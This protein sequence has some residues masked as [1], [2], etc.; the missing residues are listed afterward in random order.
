[1]QGGLAGWDGSARLGCSEFQNDSTI[2]QIV[3]DV[4]NVTELRM[5]AESMG[6]TPEWYAHV[7]SSSHRLLQ[8]M[9]SSVGAGYKQHA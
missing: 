5:A 3:L 2:Q 9:E 8:V 1:M 7:G 4:C 6:T